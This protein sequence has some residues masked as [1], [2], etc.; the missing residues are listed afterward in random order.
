MTCQAL[1]QE[2][3]IA[4]D[5][6]HQTAVLTKHVLHRPLGLLTH[7]AAQVSIEFRFKWLRRPPTES[8]PK[9]VH[10]FD[11]GGGEGRLRTIA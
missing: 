9:L 10:L 5:E 6:L 3:V 11:L 2:R 7:E 8:R 1:I 4:I